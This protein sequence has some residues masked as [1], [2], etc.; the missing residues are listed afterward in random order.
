[1]WEIFE[2]PP[3]TP[4]PAWIFIGAVFGSTVLGLI[5]LFYL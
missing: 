5:I 2:W 3:R 4:R 1:M